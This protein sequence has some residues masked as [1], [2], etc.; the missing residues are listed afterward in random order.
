MDALAIAFAFGISLLVIGAGGVFL[1]G[2]FPSGARPQSMQGSGGGTLIA[3]VLIAT[4]AHGTIALA[5]SVERLPAA[6]LIISGGLGL[7]F[8]P[9]VFQALP[10][11]LVDTRGGALAFAVAGASGALGWSLLP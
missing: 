3:L 6:W 9:L 4:I 5:T 2:M 7:L 11:A 8:A 1:S 10:G